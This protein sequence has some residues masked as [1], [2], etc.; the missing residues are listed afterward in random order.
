MLLRVRD[1]DVVR[2]PGVFMAAHKRQLDR[3]VINMKYASDGPDGKLDIYVGLREL[4]T[5]HD[6]M[7]AAFTCID[8]G[9]RARPTA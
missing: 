1:F 3:R 8:C 5:G 7:G 4:H 2:T 9:S 6:L